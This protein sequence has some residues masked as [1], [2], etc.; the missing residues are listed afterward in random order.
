VRFLT[1]SEGQSRIARG[2]AKAVE[3]HFAKQLAQN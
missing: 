3:I 2:L 1:S